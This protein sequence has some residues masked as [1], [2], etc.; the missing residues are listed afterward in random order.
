MEEDEIA[1]ESSK[2]CSLML[3][4]TTEDKVALSVAASTI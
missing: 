3:M 2:C 1:K 4:G